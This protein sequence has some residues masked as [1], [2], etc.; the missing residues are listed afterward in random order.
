MGNDRNAQL[1][2]NPFQSFFS[3][4][5]Y[6]HSNYDE[7]KAKEY[8]PTIANYL[9]IANT[10]NNSLNY[11][12][13]VLPTWQNNTIKPNIVLVICES[14]S[15]YK[16]SMWGNPL[17]PTPFFNSICEK[18]IFFDHCFTPHFGTARG[19]WATISG[20]PD[21]LLE[22]TASRNP[23]IVD[24]HSIIS[25]FKD[26]EKY[27]FIGGSTSW[28]NIKGLL[29]NNLDGLHLYEGN[30]YKDV[31]KIDVWGISDKNLFLQA[32]HILGHEPKP[33]FAVIQTA[34]NHRPYTIPKEDRAEFRDVKLSDDSL[35]QF[36][37]QRNDELNAFR[38]TDFCF[39]KFIEAA[40][41]EK[42]FN[43]T[44]FVFVGDHG[45]RGDAGNMFPKA[46]TDNGLTSFHVPLLFYSPGLLTS[47]RYSS[48]CSQLDVLPTIAGL[49]RIP[50]TNTAMGR[51]LLKLSDSAMNMAFIIDH[52]T[53][54]VGVVSGNYFYSK[55][56]VSGEQNLVSIVNNDVLPKNATYDSLSH[57]LSHMT[58]AFYETSK[59]LL[60]HNKKKR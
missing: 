19:V 50:Y 42:Y 21:V 53:R 26:Y 48:N 14:F 9:G 49:A 17:N 3:S 24:Q 12:R 56:L 52:D 23:L 46:W 7:Q 34:D 41:Q 60:F 6:R 8:Y 15:A 16:S 58:D 37:F 59:Y 51:D 33:F 32:S 40:Q 45:I 28:A 44:I 30:D 2:L 27:Y 35:H 47:A 10:P 22:N 29:M 31:P 38:F 39:K 13:E 5:T 18:G 36:G 4:F 54:R 11:N 57:A 20:I 1:A 43:N 25:D 55:H